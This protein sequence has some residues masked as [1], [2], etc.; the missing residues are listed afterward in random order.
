MENIGKREENFFCF[1]FYVKKD[2]EGGGGGLCWWSDLQQE[3]VHSPNEVLD[4][5][6]S[7][8]ATKQRWRMNGARLYS[9]VRT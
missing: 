2:E 7:Q 9:R 1:L 5:I 8:C 4:K 6:M 3:A